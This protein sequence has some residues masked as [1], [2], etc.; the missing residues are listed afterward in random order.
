MVLALAGD[1]TITNAGAFE[2]GRFSI[3]GAGEGAVAGL[4]SADDWA[5][6]WLGLSIKVVDQSVAVVDVSFCFHKR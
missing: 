5:F 6:E 3:A 2:D 1:S 4:F